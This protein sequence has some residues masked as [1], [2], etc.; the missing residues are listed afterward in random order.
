[1]LKLF[2]LSIFVGTSIQ[3]ALY[4]QCGGKNHLG[5]FLVYLKDGLIFFLENN[6]SIFR[7]YFL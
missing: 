5:H 6:S 4:G 7:G 2:I 1:M 3:V